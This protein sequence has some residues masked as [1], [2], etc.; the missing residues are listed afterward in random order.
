MSTHHPTIATSGLGSVF[1]SLTKTL[2]STT[3]TTKNVPVSINATVVGGGGDLPQLFQQLQSNSLSTRCSAATKLTESLDKYSISSIPE[4]WYLARDMCD[5]RMSSQVRRTALKL[6]LSCIKHDDDAVG[7]RLRYFRDIKTYCQLKVGYKLDPD[8]DLFLEALKALTN[9][10]RE[11]HD[12]CIYDEDKNIN[13]F[14]TSSL[15]VVSQFAS[16]YRLQDQ[17]N[18]EKLLKQDFEFKVLINTI[19][20]V[21]NCLK[22]SFTILDEEIVSDIIRKSVMISNSTTNR[23]IISNLVD[24]LHSV[25]FFGSIPSDCFELV[26]TFFCKIYSFGFDESLTKRI[27]ECIDCLSTEDSIFVL[28]TS[29]TSTIQQCYKTESSDNVIIQAC[30]G[31]IEILQRIQIVNAADHRPSI[32]SCY[33]NIYSAIRNASLHNNPRLNSAFLRYFDRLF[34]KES[35]FENFNIEFNESF[36]KILPFQLW[37]SNT[38]S[39][40]D[41]LKGLRVNSEQDESYLKSICLSLQSL[42]ENHELTTPKDKL[43]NFL[44]HNYKYLTVE[45]IKFVLEFYN[46]ERLCSLLN[47]FWKDNCLKILN[48]FYYNSSNIEAKVACLRVI[49]E[50]MEISISIFS[51]SDINY[52]IMFDILRRS[53]G[54]RD[55]IIIDYLIDNLF[56]F[57]ALHTSN[58][59]FKQLCN[60]FVV[61]LENKLSSAN[62]S[63]NQTD[64]LKSLVSLSSVSQRTTNSLSSSLFLFLQIAKAIARVFLVSISNNNPEKAQECYNVMIKMAQYAIAFNESDLLM[65][66]S[67][68]LIRIRVTSDR[69]I[70]ISKPSDMTGLAV[71]FKRNTEDSSFNND[72]IKQYKWVYPETVPYLP[73]KLYDKPSRVYIARPDFNTPY[74]L[75]EKES[76][77][78]GIDMTPW[79][80][81]ILEIMTKFVDWEIYSFVWA[82]F[83]SQLANIDLFIHNEEEISKLKNIICDQ[84]TLNLSHHIKLP[85][86]I[87]RADIQVASVRT[88]T[89]I[90]GYHNNFS[91][92]DEDQI[93][94]SLIIGLGSW[95]KTAIPCINILT[96]C[97]YEMPLS[98]KKYLSVIL[99]TLQTRVTSAFASTH[100]LEFLLS[101]VHLPS[102]TSNF[103]LDEFRRVFGIA[104]KLIQYANDMKKRVP[105]EDDR[106]NILQTHGVDA[107]VDQTPS[108]QSTEFTPIL[109]QYMLS[110][111]Y[112]VL[113]TWFLKLHM[114]DRK[115][116][117][118]FILKNLILCN[119][120]NEDL[121]DQ[122]IGYLDFIIRFTYSDL[123]LKIINSTAPGKLGRVSQTANLNRWIVGNSVI[124]IDTDY[125]NGD[126]NL[127]VRRPTG[128]CKLMIKLEHDYQPPKSSNKKVEDMNLI[129]PNYFLLQLFDHIDVSAMNTKPIPIIEDSIIL[130]ALNVLDRIPTVEFHKIGIIYI[131]N[132]QTSEL[133]VLTNKIGSRSYQ[134]FLNKIGDLVKLKQNP[135]QIYVGSLDTENDI[136]GAYARYWRDTTTQVIF[137]I[138]TMMNNP[139]FLESDNNNVDQEEKQRIVDLKK[140]HIGN[141]Y[142]NIYY[143]ES[144]LEYNFNLIKSQFNFLN[145]VISPHTISSST[146]ES[147]NSEMMQGTS[148][149]RDNNGSTENSIGDS[150]GSN[151]EKIYNNQRSSDRY[152]KVKAYRRYGVPGMFATSHFKIIS[153]ANLPNFIRNLAI[154]A[155]QFANV[156]HANLSGSFVSNWSQRVK[157]FKVLREKTMANH[158]TLRQEELQSK[159]SNESY[160]SNITT[161]QSLF[162]QLQTPSNATSST[163]PSTAT[164]NSGDLHSNSKDAVVNDYKFEYLSS[165]DEGLHPNDEIYQLIEFNSYTS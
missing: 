2:K 100:T 12:F 141:N 99:T 43:I 86:D 131:G 42:Y 19:E 143:D 27:W 29:L 93:I 20:F 94:N 55:E 81:L 69:K 102:L 44:I 125:T 35:Y 76:F 152:Y 82:H 26:V 67:K 150:F 162:E 1:K 11:I 74:A 65:I 14:L 129:N 52:D 83:C 50:S 41:I 121:D 66:V 110:L 144:G 8:Y 160:I 108:N 105:H 136:D 159:V 88:L 124:S 154:I 75:N 37:Y 122:T 45:N 25:I 28:I 97:C 156:W 138:T 127:I 106:K 147:F 6:L 17:I 51:K 95:E 87:T 116:L 149:S 7:T 90:L 119:E 53:L 101:L 49:K 157:Q 30:I 132:G 31:A 163:N 36:E 91:K 151:S 21:K 111:S 59:G 145:I 113:S 137:H 118:S 134:N 39:M 153:E 133:E 165:N 63:M 73:D 46:E 80:N 89:P 18:D 78:K 155:D 68:C 38:L 62:V 64:K 120:S 148:G 9:D 139:K 13:V 109:S 10:G 84:L 104:F 16:N 34:S 140:R 135:L 142:V 126:T 128:V 107:Q 71:S 61:Q 57:L 161:T 40:Y 32:D 117:S 130:R 54:E 98:V 79:F 5:V 23:L 115:K 60:V 77:L 48:Y 114:K 33:L 164:S 15:A 22:Y 123:P 112:N 96:V 4:V 70:Y 85:P 58:N 92:Y 3:S 72:L 158:E 56:I 47:P 146:V 24:I 103:T